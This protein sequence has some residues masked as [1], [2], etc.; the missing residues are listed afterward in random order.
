M[1]ARSCSLAVVVLAAFTAT[2]A[3]QVRLARIAP[4]ATGQDSEYAGS[5][6]DRQL[7]SVDDLARQRYSQYGG[8]EQSCSP[9]R[10]AQQRRVAMMQERRTAEQARR[11]AAREHL[12][13][14]I[15]DEEQLAVGKFRMAH[16]L[17]QDG[18]TP[19]ARK[20]LGDILDK[21]PSTETAIQARQTLARL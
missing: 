16:L 11:Q 7:P 4:A 10:A 19:A 20:W 12:P 15:Q 6:P 5:Q 21:F 2:A 18:N 9:Q 8:Y 13:R 17:W 3:A 14:P 1:V